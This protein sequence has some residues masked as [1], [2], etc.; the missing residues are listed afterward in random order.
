M[1]QTRKTGSNSSTTPQNTQTVRTGQNPYAEGSRY[2]DLWLSNPWTPEKMTQ[3]QTVWD[4][5]ANAL[6]FRSAYDTAIDQRA[7][8]AAE[9]DA[10]IVQLQGEDRYNDPAAQA[11][12]LQNA[13]INTAL[14]GGVEG[15]AAA[16]FAQEATPPEITP[17]ENLTK[18]GGLF[19]SISQAIMFSAGMTNQIAGALGAFADVEGKKIS[20]NLMLEQLVEKFWETGV[21][22]LSGEGSLG[23]KYSEYSN[24]EFAQEMYNRARVYARQSGYSS[25]KEIEKFADRMMSR[26]HNDK[27]GYYNKWKNNETARR[28]FGMS[29]GSRF[30]TTDKDLK[31]IVQCMQPLT[32]LYDDYIALSSNAKALGAG[33]EA[34]YN[35]DF[36][37]QDA[38]AADNAENASRKQRE[39]LDKNMNSAKAEIM[40]NLSEE[41]KNGNKWAFFLSL[42][43][44][45]LF[46]RLEGAQVS[47]SSSV[48]AQGHTTSNTNW[49]F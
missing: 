9:Y 44:P 46:T 12:R 33:N 32:D 11:A 35:R 1:I 41:A 26:F 6:G 36:N 29:L 22:D 14:T 39:Q 25:E 43:L 17:D 8:A 7:Q 37:A 15:A 16:E 21:P 34:L 19:N 47:G 18:I 49:A 40:K 38:A 24:D 10:Q 30:D 27:E 3:Q 31:G 20:N 23:K 45:V 42:I 48:N 13:G 4:K 28:Q 5:V 2:Y